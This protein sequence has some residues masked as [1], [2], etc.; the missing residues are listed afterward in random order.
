MLTNYQELTLIARIEEMRTVSTKLAL[1]KNDAIFK[2]LSA[3]NAF[4]FID[5]EKY[6]E[7]DER[8]KCALMKINYKGENK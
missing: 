8:R 4:G 3:L 1:H 7:L 6:A 5:A 2:F